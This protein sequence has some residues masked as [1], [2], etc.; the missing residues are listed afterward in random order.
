M[1]DILLALPDVEARQ[2][3]TAVHI[4]RRSLFDCLGRSGSEEKQRATTGIICM[5]QSDDWGCADHYREKRPARCAARVLLACAVAL[6]ARSAT[7]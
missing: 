7:K 6:R 5:V 4:H 3:W 1:K 2:V